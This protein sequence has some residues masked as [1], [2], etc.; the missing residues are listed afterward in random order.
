MRLKLEVF[1][2]APDPLS[3]LPDDPETMARE[4]ARLAGFDDGYAAGWDDATAAQ[5]DEQTRLQAELARNLQ[6]LS[7]TF[8][9][10]RDHVLRALRPLVEAMATQLLPELA[11][12]ALAPVIV[13]ALM[14]LANDLADAPVTLHINPAAK[15]AVQVFVE[16][17]AGLPVT[18]I[19]EPALAEGQAIL[20]LG[21]AEM[22][23]DL[24]A[25]TAEISA[26]VNA[27]FDL[28]ELETRHE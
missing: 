20:T 26:A 2:P 1:Q 18:L 22:R 27:F 6:G 23:I 15:A 9:E 24:A 13:D 4:D 8:Q 7:F 14:P 16:R 3:L 12:A 21:P 28:A 19:D 11:R 5:S 10:A 17:A 25:A